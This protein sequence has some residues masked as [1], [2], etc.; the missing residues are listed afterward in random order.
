MID[1][2]HIF[3]QNIFV[4]HYHSKLRS[5][6]GMMAREKTTDQLI[7]DKSLSLRQSKQDFQN[8]LHP[9]DDLLSI[10]RHFSPRRILAITIIGIALAEV[11]AMIVVYFF[12]DWPYVQQVLLDASIMTVIIFPLLYFLSFRPLLAYIQRHHQS[13]S[14]LEVRLRLMEYANAHSLDELLQYTLDQVESMTGS[15]IGFFHFLEADQKTIRLQAWST[16]T[17]QNMC[18]ADGKDSHY[19]VEQA[20]V[21]A[22]AIRYQQSVIHNDYA[23]LSDRKGLPEGHA[24]V[25][26]EMVVPILRGDKV[27][28]ILGL[29]N[30]SQDYTANDVQLVSTLADFAWDVVKQKQAENELRQSEEKFRTLVDWTYDW[31]KWL[32]P[33][34]KIVYISPSC[35]R[36]TGYSP[37]EF[38]TDPDLLTCIVHPDDRQFY[39]D[40][41]IIIH[42]A[43]AGPI[44]IEYRIIA[45]DGSEHWIEHVCRPLFGPDGR[46]LGRRVSNRDITQ[47]KQAEKKIIEQR[48]K[49]EILT[50]AIQTIQ[51]DIAR[52][53]HDTL[54]QNISFLRMNLEYLSEANLVPQA[55]LQSKI[56]TMTKAA[57][58]SYDLI[59][60]MLAIL[61]SGD[62][63]DPLSLFSRYAEQVAERSAFQVEITSRGNACQLSPHQIRQLFYIFREALSNIEK[64]A[65]AGQVSSEFIWDDQALTLVIADNGRGFD[66]NA[67][68]TDGHYGLKFMH[69]R[70]KLLKGSLSIQS[71]PGEGLKITVVVPYEYDSSIQ[72][73]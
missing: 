18:Q 12:R 2:T 59:R 49:E 1:K 55:D 60:A 54:G 22:D 37:E 8:A 36:I 26:R 62:T 69:D 72:S 11:I 47:R 51:T 17:L 65:N 23:A 16:N 41:H 61:Q 40:H 32:D 15:T 46:Y 30:K 43:Q 63:A 52:D 57:N 14:I 9:R 3:S 42:D 29:G 67:V 4:Y 10:R 53:L 50:Q 20:G 70:A 31:E 56:Q 5:L 6:A 39:E 25:V 44:E 7:Q 71:A 27:I 13:E 35:E 28:A 68:Q 34:G 64:H 38:I 21:W 66:P 33:F 45:R 73:Q 24:K 58:E 48:Q 19:D